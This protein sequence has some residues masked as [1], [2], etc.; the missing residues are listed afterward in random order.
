ML[1]VADA[2]TPRAVLPGSYMAA[3]F[4]TTANGHGG[5][6]VTEAPPTEPRSLLTDAEDYTLPH[7]PQ[8]RDARQCWGDQIA[9]E[10]TQPSKRPLLVGTGKLAV[11]GY[12]RRKNGCEFA[13]LCHTSPFTTRQ[14]STFTD[15]SRRVVSAGRI[16]D[17][18]E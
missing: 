4:V 13:V 2:V 12:V 8:V 5:T 1:T 11:S 3:I 10:R 9:T 18:C 15:W 6:L 14:N 16:I 7:S 17:A